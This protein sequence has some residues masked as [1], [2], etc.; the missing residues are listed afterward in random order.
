[1]RAIHAK[2]LGL[3]SMTCLMVAAIVPAAAMAIDRNVS[4]TGTLNSVVDPSRLSPLDLDRLT[5]RRVIESIEFPLG[6]EFQHMQA[7]ST[8]AVL[9]AAF[10]VS[11]GWP[12][13]ADE[14]DHLMV[15]AL[16][17]T[18]LSVEAVRVATSDVDLR[19]V[20]DEISGTLDVWAGD[21]SGLV[22]RVG[23]DYAQT[24][25]EIESTQQSSELEERARDHFDVSMEF[26]VGAPY[27]RDGDR[28]DDNS[29][30][31]AGN[32]LHFRQRD[33]GR[34]PANCTQGYSWRKWSSSI[35][36]ASTAGHCFANRTSVFV[37]NPNQRIGYVH[38]RWFS[39]DGPTDFELIR[40]TVGTVDSSVWIHRPSADTL[41]TVVAADNDNSADSIGQPMCIGGA[42]NAH[43]APSSH[44]CGRLSA[45]HQTITY[46]NDGA[47]YQIRGLSCISSG[48]DPAR[49]GDSGAP[50]FTNVK[51]N[52]VFAWGQHIGSHNGTGG[53]CAAQ[54]TPVL[55]ISHSANATLIT[56]SG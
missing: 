43:D 13:V 45:I 41:R 28:W 10:S 17:R 39:D 37:G 24:S 15:E 54:F 19:S 3:A 50:V 16:V 22:I 52:G 47:P 1:M 33:A 46:T 7:G 11:A 6:I 40:T 26:V 44:A 49:P 42:N 4:A 14:L 27:I 25:V 51:N 34:Y 21:L 55:A 12:G 9:Q 35:R 31:T 20:A 32:A 53:E 29:P 36:Y 2:A 48:R 5:A 38:G 23:P 8:P 18:G 30:W 56:N